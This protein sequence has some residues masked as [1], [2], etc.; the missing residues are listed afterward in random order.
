MDIPTKPEEMD[1][2]EMQFHYFRMFDTDHNLRLD[3]LELMKGALFHKHERS[4]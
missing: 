1:E 2:K 3:G 4:K